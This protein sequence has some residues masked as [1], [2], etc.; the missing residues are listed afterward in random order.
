MLCALTKPLLDA[1]TD[2]GAIAPLMVFIRTIFLV[3]ESLSAI[4]N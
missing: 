3:A 2:L 1:K 4:A